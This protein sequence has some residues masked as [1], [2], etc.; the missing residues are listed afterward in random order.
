MSMSENLVFRRAPRFDIKTSFSFG[1][2]TYEAGI[3][4]SEGTAAR[5]PGGW[6]RRMAFD[7]LLRYV[8]TERSAFF[9]VNAP[10]VTENHRL[11]L[12]RREKRYLGVQ[13]LPS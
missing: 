8:R 5:S 12:F 11:G 2:I 3:A 7:V 4:L 13:F 9:S 1:V 6:R 10:P